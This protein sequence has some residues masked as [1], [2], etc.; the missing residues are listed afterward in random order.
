MKKLIIISVIFIFP[1]ICFSQDK[2]QNIYE[3]NHEHKVLIDSMIKDLKKS[4]L[5][6][7]MIIYIYF[8]DKEIKSFPKNIIKGNDFHYTFLIANYNDSIL[9]KLIANDTL[10]KPIYLKENIFRYEFLDKTGYLVKEVKN[11]LKFTPEDIGGSFFALIYIKNEKNFFFESYLDNQGA[12]CE[13]P[14]RLQYRT[15]LANIIY[16]T[17]KKNLP[18]FE[19]ECKK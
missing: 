8:K 6:E 12:Y 16:S 7:F 13:V 19:F 11:C 1:A 17:L 15:E 9:V 3:Y 4:N 2:L 10:Y 18:L 5:N 14:E